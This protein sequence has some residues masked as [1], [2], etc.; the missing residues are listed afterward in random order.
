MESAA[1][2]SKHPGGRPRK[3]SEPSQ[4]VT[5]TLPDRTLA[6]LRS[7]DEDRARAIVKAVDQTV[8]RGTRPSRRVEVVEMSPGMGILVVPGSRSL[9]SIPWLRM[10]EVAPMRH[11]LAIVSG[12]PIEK[13][14]VALLDL[15]DNAK[16]SVP[17][18]V[19]LLR[20]L[21]EKIGDLRRGQRISK[22]EILVITRREG[23]V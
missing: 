8:G 14:E 22:A 10:I 19:E 1:R 12:T 13:V 4:P 3:F 2:K 21:R 15:I 17:D 16:I 11:L 20:M 18:E 6:Q 23:K 9:R 5:V 7:I